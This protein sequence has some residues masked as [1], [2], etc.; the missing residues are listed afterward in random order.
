MPPPIRLRIA[1]HRMRPQI[2]QYE[3]MQTLRLRLAK[4]DHMYTAPAIEPDDHNDV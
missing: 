1:R 3:K 2:Q 4:L